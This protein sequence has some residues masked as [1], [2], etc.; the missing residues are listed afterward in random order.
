M[1]FPLTSNDNHN[2]RSPGIMELSDIISG[3]TSNGRIAQYAL[4]FGT[5][6]ILLYK[7]IPLRV[8]ETQMAMESESVEHVPDTLIPS[9][10]SISYSLIVVSGMF[11]VYVNKQLFH[12]WIHHGVCKLPKIE[13]DKKDIAETLLQLQQNGRNQ[14]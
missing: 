6:D 14:S 12:N 8:T 2:P 3:K 11:V 10:P 5:M 7:R 1:I 9:P 13:V 4:M